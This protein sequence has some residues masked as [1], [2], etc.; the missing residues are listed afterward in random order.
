[1]SN[2]TKAVLILFLTLTIIGQIFSASVSAQS[3]TNANGILTRDTL[4]SKVNSPYTLTG[5]V[6]VAE[7]V[8]LTIEPGVSVQFS[9]HYLQ[10]NGTLVAK[11]TNSNNIIFE[12][13]NGAITFNPSSGAWNEQTKTGSIVENAIVGCYLYIYGSPKIFNDTIHCGVYV[14]QGSPTIS[15]NTFSDFYHGLSIDGNGGTVAVTDN[16]FSGIGDVGIYISDQNTIS[17]I[18]QRNLLIDCSQGA[19]MV[20]SNAT[21]RDNTIINNRNDGIIVRTPL[22]TIMYNNIQNNHPN[23]SNWISSNVSVP[24]NWWGTTDASAINQSIYDNK[25]DFNIGTV[26]FTPFLTSPNNDAPMALDT[27]TNETQPSSLPISSQTPTPTVPE[28]LWLTL[29]PLCLIVMSIALMVRYR[30]V[31]NAI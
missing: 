31:S 7:G 18:V 16:T 28:L 11:G 1:M 3:G 27:Q 25:N 6:A 10:V 22:A 8:T 17:V 12:N 29:L 23:L 20:W 24:N 2:L 4:W 30:R 19:I 15:H 14:K 21:I 26:N 9:N 5:P 13:A